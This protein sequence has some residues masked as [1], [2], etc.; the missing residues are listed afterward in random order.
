A[1]SPRRGAAIV[2]QQR[3]TPPADGG[4]GDEAQRTGCIGFRRRKGGR[5]DQQR[6]GGGTDIAPAIGWRGDIDVLRQMLPGAQHGEADL[7]AAIRFA[8]PATLASASR[9]AMVRA[10]PVQTVSVRM[11]LASVAWP[12]PSMDKRPAPSA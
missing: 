11:R 2:E 7:I 5:D 6:T 4:S 1:V 3:G 8:V 9:H 12:A 10:S